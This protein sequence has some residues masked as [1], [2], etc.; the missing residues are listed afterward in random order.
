MMKF[1][2]N[3]LLEQLSS[4]ENNIQHNKFNSVVINF[5]KEKII[6]NNSLK[7]KTK[8]VYI[9]NIYRNIQDLQIDKKFNLSIKVINSAVN[10]LK[11]S[12]NL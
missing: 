10:K 9:S 7:P 12:N 4:F 6:L 1:L 11:I 3:E 2:T 5:I 8:L